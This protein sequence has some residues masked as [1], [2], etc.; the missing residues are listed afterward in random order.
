MFLVPCLH[1]VPTSRKH[2][3]PHQ[4]L[5]GPCLPAQYQSPPPLLQSLSQLNSFYHL[6]GMS[7]SPIHA[8]SMLS[9]AYKR[10]T[11]GHPLLG[12]VHPCPTRTGPFRANCPFSTIRFF[13]RIGY[14]NDIPHRKYNILYN[15]AHTSINCLLHQTRP[16][17]SCLHCACLAWMLCFGL[18]LADCVSKKR[19][20]GM[21][22]II[23]HATYCGKDGYDSSK[24]SGSG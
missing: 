23:V 5:R 10:P 21:A 22:M 13:R 20:K 11:Y 8:N 1:F 3:A 2:S 6:H 18:V 15:T 24:G 14:T 9:M 12:L 7:L 16:E 19:M 17:L 4:A